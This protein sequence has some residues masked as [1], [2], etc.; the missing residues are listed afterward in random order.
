MTTENEILQLKI[1]RLE[2]KVFQNQDLNIEKQLKEL[3]ARQQSKNISDE[4]TQERHIGEFSK[5]AA[6]VFINSHKRNY[7]KTGVKSLYGKEIEM[8]ILDLKL[9][10]A[11]AKKFNLPKIEDLRD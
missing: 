4:I 6:T 3:S 7:D 10:N 9:A 1:Q 8:Y 2:A 11:L 5:E